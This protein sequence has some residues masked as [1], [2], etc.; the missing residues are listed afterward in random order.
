[1]PEREKV[2]KNVIYLIFFL[3]DLCILLHFTLKCQKF[4]NA[5]VMQAIFPVNGGKFQL[6]PSEKEQ[7]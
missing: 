3:F 4:Q 7:R 2:K 5:P 6:L 1:M